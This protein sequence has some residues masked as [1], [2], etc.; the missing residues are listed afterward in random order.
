[1]DTFHPF[2]TLFQKHSFQPFSTLNAM[3]SKRTIIVFVYLDLVLSKLNSLSKIFQDEKAT[4]SMAI[5]ATK[6]ISTEISELINTEPS[7]ETVTAPKVSVMIDSLKEVDMEVFDP[8]PRRTERVDWRSKLFEQLNVYTDSL[9]TELFRRFGEDTEML[10]SFIP[11]NQKNWPDIIAHLKLPLFDTRALADEA[12]H[13]SKHINLSPQIDITS[14]SK[15]WQ[16]FLKDD[17][18]RN[19]F[20][21]HSFVSTLMLILPLGSCAV[22]RCFSYS[23]RICSDSRSTLTL[24]HVSDLVRLSQQGP[25]FPKLSDIPWPFRLSD[26]LP[27]N[28]FDSFIEKVFTLWRMSP[29]RL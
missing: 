21:E 29:R 16:S 5:M 26:I 7:I 20:P 2:C 4:L 18:T 15:F 9:V 1:M 24:S 13:I 23:N 12:R 28:E 8:T 17:Y 14:A 6:E 27:N 25:D 3:L 19:M 11:F 10:I 22:E